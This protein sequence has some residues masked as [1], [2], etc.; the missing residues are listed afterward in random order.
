GAPASRCV[1]HSEI[2]DVYSPSRRRRAPLPL[3]SR[4]SYSSRILSLYC[5]ENTRRVAR[6]ETS[7]S[8]GSLTGTACRPDTTLFITIALV[9]PQ[10]LRLTDFVSPPASPNVDPEGTNPRGQA[11]QPAPRTLLVPKP[12]PLRRL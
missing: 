10:A 9:V 11:R 1:R 6:S 3:R 8:T 7:G 2:D 12:Q 4:R 5:C